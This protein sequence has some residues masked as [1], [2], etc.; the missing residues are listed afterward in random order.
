MENLEDKTMVLIEYQPAPKG[1]IT[2]PK[3]GNFH[4]NMLEKV[5][6][7]GENG[8]I[9]LS[10]A[11]IKTACDFM[12]YIDENNLD[13]GEYDEIRRQWNNFILNAYTNKADAESQK[14]I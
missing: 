5:S 12:E 10:L 1:E 8:F 4:I 6:G 7:I 2:K 11:T 14:I 3:I 9:A 13:N